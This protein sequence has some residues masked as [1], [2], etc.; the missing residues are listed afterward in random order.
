MIYLGIDVGTTGSKVAAIDQ[1]GHVRAQAHGEYPVVRNSQGYAEIDPLAVWETVKAVI[2]SAA[3]Q[4][5]EPV[6]AIAIA[7]LG[8]SFVALDKHGNKLGN[9]MLYSDV[10]GT[11]EIKDI[12][13]K[14]DEQALYSTTGMPVNAMYTLNK[15]LWVKKHEPDLYSRIDKLFLFGDFI[16]YMLSGERCIDYSLASR[17]QFFDVMNHCWADGVLEAFDIDAA[18]LSAPV[19]PGSLIGK[20]SAVVATDL[21][22]PNGVL[23]IAGAHDQVCAALG[24]GVLAKGECVDGIGTSE[25]ITTVLNGLDQRE[26]MRRNNF[27]IEPYAIAGEYVTLAFNASGASILS[28]FCEQFMKRQ[29]I[30]CTQSDFDLI[31]G[32]CP[33]GPTNL[34]VLPHFSGSGT[35]HMDPY[36]AGAV[37]GLGL[38]TSRGDIYKA[39]IEGLSFEMM[40]NAELLKSIGTRITSIT[41]VGGGSR[42]DMLLQVKADIMGI[43]VKRLALKESG[44]MALAMLC[45]TACSDFSGLDEAVQKMVKIDKHFYPNPRYHQLYLERFNTYKSIYPNIVNLK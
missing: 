30:A 23:L 41:C 40:F 3:A 10:R 27:C 44:T 4:A 37:L 26:F 16:Y 22:L 28:W 34:F 35:P 9:S 43:P 14:F 17:T 2:A 5:G 33:A 19:A 24:S 29:G 38:N 39:F 8:E 36:S 1:N 25:C 31:E 6:K 13:V 21:N 18:M 42:S 32:E 20:V 12:L 15:L 11:D 7:S 45:A